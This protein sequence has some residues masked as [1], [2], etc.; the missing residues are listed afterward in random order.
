MD[1]RGL[2]QLG[3]AHCALLAARAFAAGSPD[4]WVDPPRITAPDPASDEGGLW[5]IVTRAERKLRRGEFLIRDQALHEY[6][7]SIACSLAGGHCPDVRVY[8]VRTPWFNA[9]M[10]PN[11]MLQVWSG[12]L[13][14]VENEAQL[15]AVLGHELGHYM[16]RHSLQGLRS[17]ESRSALGA[18][19]GPITGGLASIAASLSMFSFSRDQEREAD[20]IGVT[21]MRRAGYDPHQASVVWSNML[22]EATARPGSDA[23]KTSPMFATHPPMAERRETLARL[24]GSDGGATKEQ[25]LV[26]HLDP[27][28]RDFLDDELNR[29][30]YDESIVLLD[31]LVRRS[32]QRPDLLYYRAESRRLRGRSGDADLAL[33]DLEAAVAMPATPAEVHRALGYAYLARGDKAKARASL[34]SYL[35]AKPGAVDEGIVRNKLKELES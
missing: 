35:E 18:M 12:L 15:A 14:R 34:A 1:R 25:E 3:C 33:G 13:L 30:E 17:A 32:P 7:Q 22:A 8:V 26:Q 5:A 19:F 27:L 10:A 29:A 28:M 21:L 23:A 4:D 9:S 6:I 11:G 24:A 16:R 31:R 20:R 2:L